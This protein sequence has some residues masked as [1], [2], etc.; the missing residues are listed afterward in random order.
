MTSRFMP[1]DATANGDGSW[2]LPTVHGDW[3]IYNTGEEWAVH[4]GPAD[5]VQPDSWD[6]LFATP[7]DAADAILGA[8]LAEED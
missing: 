5:T 3:L 7:V 6:V 8:E 2:T 1:D 4:L